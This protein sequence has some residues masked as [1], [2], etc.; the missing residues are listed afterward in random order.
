ME[1]FSQTWQE[2]PSSD[3]W[4]FYLS[5][6]RLESERILSHEKV[7]IHRESGAIDAGRKERLFLYAPGDIESLLASS[8]FSGIEFWDGWSGKRYDCGELM[9]VTARA[10]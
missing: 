3:P 8:G 2:L 5:R 1:T 9:V 10:R 7:F 6:L 4:R